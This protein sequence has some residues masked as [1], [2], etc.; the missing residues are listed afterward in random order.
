MPKV[1]ID[2]QLLLAQLKAGLL[3]LTAII[4]SLRMPDPLPANPSAAKIY[5]KAKSLL[6]TDASPLDAAPDSLA[7]A[8]TVNRIVSLALGTP[9][10]GGTSTYSMWQCLRASAKWV[11]VISSD[12]LPGDIV[13]SPTGGVTGARLE[14][15]H[16]GI[17]AKHGILSNNSE[18]GLLSENYDIPTWKR[19]YT[20]FGGLPTFFYRYNG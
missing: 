16:V 6:G 13:I 12:A 11:T 15:G 14:H 4:P 18:N 9:I 20:Q 7:C 1:S 17:V 2:L 3:K 8:E 5:E 10:G 19:Y